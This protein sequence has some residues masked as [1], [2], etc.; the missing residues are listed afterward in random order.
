MNSFEHLIIS[1]R[2]TIENFRFQSESKYLK[3]TDFI[4]RFTA[5][6]NPIV[7]G[8]KWSFKGHE[9]QKDVSDDTTREQATQKCSQIGFSEIYIRKALGMVAHYNL[10]ATYVMPTKEMINSFV[11]ARFDPVI[12]NSPK[13]R[14]MITKRNNTSHKMFKNGKNL[15]IS[16]SNSEAARLSTALDMV[17]MDEFDRCDDSNYDAW[18]QRLGHSEYKIYDCFS[19]PTVSDYG[20]NALFK[21]S[22]Q[23]YYMIKCLAC[24]EWQVMTFPDSIKFKK[25]LLNLPPFHPEMPQRTG[26]DKLDWKHKYL[27]REPYIGCKK[28]DKRLDRTRSELKEWVATYESKGVSGRQISRFNVPWDP[29]TKRGHNAVTILDVFFQMNG[30]LEFYNQ[31]LG[32]PY[33]KTSDSINREN[34][35][36]CCASEA[37]GFTSLM[38]RSEGITFMGIDQGKN[39]HITIY[40]VNGV[41]LDLIYAEEK[42]MARGDDGQAFGLDEVVSEVRELCERFNTVRGVCDGSPDINLPRALA[43]AL[44]GV[45]CWAFFNKNLNAYTE[46]TDKNKAIGINR[47]WVLNSVSNMVKKSHSQFELRVPSNFYKTSEGKEF[48]S[49]FRSAKKSIIEKGDHTTGIIKK[50]T[51]WIKKKNEADHYLLSSCY[52]LVAVLFVFEPDDTDRPVMYSTGYTV[53]ETGG[54]M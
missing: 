4:S 14:S 21:Q 12:L 13:L 47:T 9:W 38:K 8:E 19:T 53:V 29:V 25:G 44:P 30:L 50:E 34:L 27:D 24:N 33:D 41:F 11:P 39:L 28:C 40:R 15:Y 31:V 46:P 36:Q 49:H 32:E 54:V 23:K 18:P 5:H 17:I 45:F 3:T 48:E 43:E 51:V 37:S 42:A 16:H 35:L 1:A 2:D 7:G 22:D 20:I 6:P 10:N 52:A 26:V